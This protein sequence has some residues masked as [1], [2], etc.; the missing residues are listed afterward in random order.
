MMVVYMIGAYLVAWTPYSI[1][2][3]VETFYDYSSPRDQG[4][5]SAAMATIPSL[6][7]KTSCVTN[8]LV[9]GLLNP[10]FRSACLKLWARA[11]PKPQWLGTLWRRCCPLRSDAVAQSSVNNNAAEA[12]GD[13]SA[14]NETLTLRN[15]RGDARRSQYLGD[16]GD[17]AGA[18]TVF[19]ATATATMAVT[20]RFLAAPEGEGAEATSPSA[21]DEDYHPAKS[22]SSVLHDES[23]HCPTTTKIQRTFQFPSSSPNPAHRHQKDQS[24]GSSTVVV[25]VAI[26]N[27]TIPLAAAAPPPPSAS[28]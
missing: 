13:N 2:A 27:E 26:E 4:V 21:E 11:C 24:I 16:D 8:P 1:M 12:A 28:N 10:L 25:V 17:T 23:P 19:T 18:N 15:H 20:T 3:L 9:Y 14:E 5:F 22:S 7:A 6:F